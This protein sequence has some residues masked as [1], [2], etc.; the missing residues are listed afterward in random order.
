MILISQK[1]IL[2]KKRLGLKSLKNKKYFKNY[3]VK[4]SKSAS[5]STTCNFCGRGGHIIS[6]CSLRN[7]SQKASS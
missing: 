4:E 6:T 3:F 5:T 1:C 2:D 7:G